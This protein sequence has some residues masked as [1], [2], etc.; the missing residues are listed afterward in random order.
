[1]HALLIDAHSTVHPGDNPG[2]NLKSISHRCHLILVAFVWELTQ[3]TIHLR[4]GCLDA[5]ST[6]CGQ[7]AGHAVTVASPKGGAPPIDGGSEAEG[8]LTAHTKRHAEDAESQKIFF[9][10]TDSQA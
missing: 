8:F 9:F 2:A 1:M 3:E 6:V 5:D 7:D 10:I 4:L